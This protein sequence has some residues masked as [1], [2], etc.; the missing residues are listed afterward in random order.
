MRLKRLGIVVAA[1]S[2]LVVGGGPAGANTFVPPS[3]G[4]IT[5]AIGPTIIDGVVI[6]PGMH[7]TV[8]PEGVD[9]VPAW[10]GATDPSSNRGARRRVR[11]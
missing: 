9:R 1:G 8:P 10:S 5:V 7:V 11:R 4:P 2:V 6:D 3:V